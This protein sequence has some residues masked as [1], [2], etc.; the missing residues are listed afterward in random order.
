MYL[1]IDPPS[2]K[3]YAMQDYRTIIERLNL[4]PHPEGGIIAG[5]GN[6]TSKRKQK[7]A[8]D[9]SSIPSVASA[10]QYCIYCLPTK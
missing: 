1:L 5:T 9:E 8:R 10:P 7:T 6:P 2:K 4:L 3:E